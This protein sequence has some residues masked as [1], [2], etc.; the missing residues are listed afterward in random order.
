MYDGGRQLALDGVDVDSVAELA[1]QPP[2]RW[3]MIHH[4][5][6]LDLE[7]QI[8]ADTGQGRSD[9]PNGQRNLL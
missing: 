3:E 7:D 2:K 1:P 8:A 5:D 6:Q 4:R 9:S